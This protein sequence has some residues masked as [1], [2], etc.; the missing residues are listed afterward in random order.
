MSGAEQIGHGK[1]VFAN[2][3]ELD[4]FNE[5]VVAQ[6]RRTGGVVEEG[7]YAGADRFLVL[8]SVGAKSGEPRQTPLFYLDVEGRWYLIGSFWGN[9][10]HPAW[11]YNLLAHPN[12][13]IE[14]KGQTL[15]AVARELEAEEREEIWA[16]LVET[17]P[18]FAEYQAKTDRRIRLFE[19]VR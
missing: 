2:R 18:N 11:V 14:V 19:L 10:K 8:H 9:Q 16:R 15:E 4:A 6:L 5:D 17:A 13:R 3:A 1:T 12:V 7:P